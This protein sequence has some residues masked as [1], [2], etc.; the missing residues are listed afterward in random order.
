[1]KVAVCME[2]NAAGERATLIESAMRDALKPYTWVR[3]LRT[4]YVLRLENEDQIPLL[5][6]GLLQCARAFLAGEVNY[7]IVP[8]LGRIDGFLPANMWPPLNE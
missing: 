1:M 5:Q 7:L 2:I 8:V 6:A 3:P 4:V